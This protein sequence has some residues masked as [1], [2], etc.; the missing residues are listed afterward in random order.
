MSLNIETKTRLLAILRVDAAEPG[1][2]QWE[3]FCRLIDSH[4]KPFL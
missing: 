4:P 2:L 1:K 3:L